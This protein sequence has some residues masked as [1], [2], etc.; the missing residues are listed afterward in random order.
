MLAAVLILL[1]ILVLVI[2]LVVLILVILLILLVIHHDFLQNILYCG[3]TAKIVC[4]DI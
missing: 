4:P 1:V 3:N 2:L